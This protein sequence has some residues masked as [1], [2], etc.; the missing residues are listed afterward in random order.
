MEDTLMG[1]IINIDWDITTDPSE[2]SLVSGYRAGQ[3]PTAN[4]MNTFF[5][6]LIAQGNLNSDWLLELTI[7]VPGVVEAIDA[8][9]VAYNAHSA[10]LDN[11]MAELIALVQTFTEDS[12]EFDTWFSLMKDQLSTDAAGN[13]QLQIDETKTEVDDLQGL[14]GSGVFTSGTGEETE[15][16]L[17]DSGMLGGQLPAYYAK[18]TDV[19]SL[20]NSLNVINQGTFTKALAINT[21]IQ[22]DIVFAKPFTNTNYSVVVSFGVGTGTTMFT[23]MS[24]QTYGVGKKTINGFTLFTYNGSASTVN[25]YVD[26]I[27]IGS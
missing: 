2:I 10:E 12:S 20:N 6:S 24:N 19:D 22:T 26:W 18:Q 23:G 13:L 4:E 21:V 3:T 14:I 16:L 25:P 8:V 9:L 17:Q 15:P 7:K 1:Q 5:S 11:A 27:A